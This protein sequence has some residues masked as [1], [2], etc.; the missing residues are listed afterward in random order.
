MKNE[1]DISE[2]ENADKE[3]NEKAQETVTVDGEFKLTVRKLE[4]P[5]RPRGVLAE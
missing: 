5:V 1:Q 4:M 2:T 3:V